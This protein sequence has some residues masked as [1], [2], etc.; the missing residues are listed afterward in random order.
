V[1]CLG[2]YFG[3]HFVDDADIGEGSPCHD[4]VIASSG[5][6]RVEVFLFD[7]FLF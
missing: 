7:A 5:S 4:E 1:D 3:D 2:A 6:V